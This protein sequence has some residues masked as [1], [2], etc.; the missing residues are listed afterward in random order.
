MIFLSV[1]GV[2]DNAVDQTQQVV[3][4]SQSIQQLEQGVATVA[5]ALDV[6][7]DIAA[8][9][10]EIN[11]VQYRYANASLTLDKADLDVANEAMDNIQPQ[12]ITLVKSLPNGNR[13]IVTLEEAL[14][15]SRIFGNKMNELLLDDLPNVAGDMARG[16]NAQMLIVNDVLD[17][18]SRQ[19]VERV[20][21]SISLVT[22][23]TEAVKS[24]GNQVSSSANAI[25]AASTHMS[26]IVMVVGIVVIS[27][28]C[29]IAVYTARSL[30]KATKQV[31]GVLNQ[32]SKTQNLTIRVNRQE[33]D[34]LGMIARDVDQMMANFEKVV[35][36]VDNTADEVSSEITS[37]SQRSDSLN[38]SATEL[39]NSVDSIS[40]AVVQLS[41]S[42][43]EVSNNAT[44]TAENTREAHQ[45]GRKGTQIVN[46]SIDNVKSLSNKLADSQNTIQQLEQDVGEIGGVLAVIEGIAEQTN[47]LALN[48]AIEAARA[49]EQGRGFAV[50][51]DEVRSL[52]SRTQESTV[53]I[54]HTIDSLRGRTKDVVE[55]MQESIN[56]SA[57]NVEQAKQASTAITQISD[58]LTSILDLNQLIA[59]AA[60]EQSDVA[61][62][63]SNRVNRLSESAQDMSAVSAQ[64]QSA[65]ERMC[66][67]GEQLKN[68]V[69]I[70][71][72]G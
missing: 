43:S 3:E 47:L 71:N 66:S 55:T 28:M 63:I 1:T 33:Q 70:F 50:V 49:G 69:S 26:T 13:E 21:D 29:M 11:T 72:H 40:T 51:A 65:G 16:L 30:R 45:I 9:K 2:R 10:N 58:S 32:I 12:V 60:K 22:Q 67:Q 5:P 36:D 18:L 54:R 24:S 35:V 31:G 23:Q 19:S 57:Q 27:L 41:A 64:N 20:N 56:A 34:E 14:G 52:A 4:Q 7:K 6:M 37:M 38:Q 42:A 15:A 25:V 8:L 62:D 61:A 48:A 46:D 39:M 53:E 17:Q 68:A 44:S 59:T